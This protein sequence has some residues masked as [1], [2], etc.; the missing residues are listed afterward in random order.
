[1]SQF[2][3]DNPYPPALIS[4][5]NSCKFMVQRAGLGEWLSKFFSDTSLPLLT[6]FT[7]VDWIA[8][9]LGAETSNQKMVAKRVR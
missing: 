2:N 1:M 6:A 9:L 5:A 4:R 3:R 8:L 7:V